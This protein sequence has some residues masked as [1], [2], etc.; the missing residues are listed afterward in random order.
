MTNENI[1]KADPEYRVAMAELGQMAGEGIPS[2]FWELDRKPG[3]T[4]L[5]A[6]ARKVSGESSNFSYK[7]AW[8]TLIGGDVAGMLLAYPLTEVDSNEEIAAS[9]LFIQPLLK[10]EQRVKGS[11][12]IN[13]LATYATYR[14]QGV[15]TRLMLNAEHIATQLHINNLSIQV[16]SENKRALNLYQKLGYRVIEHLPVV[17]HPCHPY[18]EDI[19][20]LVKHI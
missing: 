17:P 18:R 19:V 2:F 13:M 9:P 14:Q 20:L 8:L 3:E 6:G 4:A 1:I 10:L 7:N 15:A 5:A 11:F 12:Y 16:F